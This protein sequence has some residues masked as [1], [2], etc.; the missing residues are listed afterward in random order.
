MLLAWVPHERRFL[1]PCF[2]VSRPRDGDK[3]L[4]GFFNLIGGAVDLGHAL[5]DTPAKHGQSRRSMAVD[6]PASVG[7]VQ[8]LK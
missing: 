1:H 2:G 8:G 7:E 6:A 4:H 5:E 3:N